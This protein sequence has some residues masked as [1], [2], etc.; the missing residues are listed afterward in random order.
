ML[1]NVSVNTVSGFY[2]KFA[3]GATNRGRFRAYYTCQKKVCVVLS[4]GYRF[5]VV[6]VVRV[7]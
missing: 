2:Y 7:R 4:F 1:L 3:T 5:F 6:F